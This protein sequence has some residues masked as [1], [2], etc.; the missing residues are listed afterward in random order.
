VCSDPTDDLEFA[1][2]PLDAA[3]VYGGRRVC[4]QHAEAQPATRGNLVAALREIPN[5]RA[6]FGYS[7]HSNPGHLGAD[8]ACHLALQDGKLTAETIFV[9]DADGQPIPFC[10]RVLLSACDSAG[11]S[12]A[13][14]GEWLGLTAA[15]L[16]NGAREVIATSW[17]VWDLPVTRVVD[18]QLMEAL[19]GAEDIAAAL[20]EVQLTRLAEWRSS[21]SDYSERL[22]PE[23]ASE[24]LPLVWSAYQYV[25]LPPLGVGRR[26]AGTG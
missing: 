20:R 4:A 8:L 12:G 7:G 19:S 22:V 24:S 3:E 13:G 21:T 6:V 9:G 23:G 11:S 15:V 10:E 18:V 2:L 14:S 5:S 1:T 25:G 26:V 16:C 17:P